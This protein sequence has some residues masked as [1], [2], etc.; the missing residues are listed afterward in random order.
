MSKNKTFQ[1]R[2]LISAMQKG[3]FVRFLSLS[4][5]FVLLFSVGAYSQQVIGSYPAMDGG[6]ENQTGT[7]PTASSISSAQTTWTTQVAAMGVIS[8]TGGRSGPKYV[9]YSQSGTPHKRLQ[10]PTTNVPTGAYRVQFWYQGDLDGTITASNI[11]GAVSGDGTATPAYA[12]YVSANTGST[13]TLYE[14][15]VTTTT[16][17]TNIGIGAVSV[18][19]TAQFKI[20]DYV[21]YSGSTADGTAPNAPTAPTQLSAAATQQTISWTAPSGGVDGGGYM[22]V[23][24]DVDPTTTPNTKGVYA[25]GNFVAGTEK[26]VYLGTANSFTD[27]GLTASTSYS[28]RIYAVDKAFNYSSAASI[29]ASTVAPSFASEP[30]TQASGVTFASI[31]IT[32]L[33]INWTG[34][35]GSNSLVVVKAGSAVDTDPTDGNTYTGNAAF[36]SGT[37]IGTGNYAVYNGSGNSVTLT[38][39][40]KLTTYY[41]KVY[42]FNGSAGTEN[43]LITTP[44]SGSQLTLPGEIYSNGTGGGNWST[45]GSWAGGVVPTQ[46][47]NVTIAASDVMTFT[48]SGKCYNLTIPTGTKVW[49]PAANTL[50]IYGTSLVCNGTGTLGDASIANSLLTVQFGGN[51]SIS[52]SSSSI[53][54]YKITPV[55]STSN[56]SVTFDAN[57][58]ITYGTVGLAF[59]NA[60]NDNITYTVS[61]G[62]TVTVAGALSATSSQTGVGA[63]NQT[64]KVYG[65]L[66]IGGSLNTTVASGKTFSLTVYSGGLIEVAKTTSGKGFNLSPA[67]SVQ[68]ATFTVNSGG[69]IK[70]YGLVD[71]SSTSYTGA[72]TG[73]GTFSTAISGLVGAP[74]YPEV[75]LGNASGLDATTG[76]IRTSAVNFDAGTGFLFVGTSPQVTGSNMPSTIA[77]LTVPAAGLTLSKSLTVN[78]NLNSSGVLT[79]G[80]NTFSLKGT[81][82]GSSIDGAN[83]TIV[84]IGDGAQGIYTLT[85]VN[86]LTVN[87]VIGQTTL[88]FPVTVNG[89]LTLAAGN[90]NNSTNNI[91]LANGATIVRTAGT[92]STAPVFGTS[93]NVTYNGASAQNT[94]NELPTSSSVLNNLIINNPAGITLAANATAANLTVNPS[95]VLNVGIGKQLTV[96]TALTNDGAINL[97]SDATG[98]ATI[99]TPASISGSG[100]STVQQYLTTGRNWYVSSPVSGATAAVFNPAGLSNILYSYDETHGSSAPWPAIT[101][102]ATGLTVMKG[103]VANMASSGVVTFS[104]TLNTGAQEIGLTQTSGQV[105]NGFNLVGNP[106]PSYLDWSSITKTNMLTTMWYRTKTSGDVYTFDTYNASGNIATSNGA[107]AVTNLIPPMQA[108]WVHVQTGFASSTLSV[109]NNQRAHADNS[110]NTF[111]AKASLETQP[112][113]RLQVSNGTN[114]DQALVY[115]NATA[116]NGFDSYDSPKLSNESASMPEIYTLAGS[117]QLVINGVN[118]ATELALGFTTGE[119]NNFSIKASQ[120]ANFASGTQIILRDNLLNYEQDLTLADYNFYS[121]VTANNETRFT[122]LFKAPSVATGINPNSNA[123]VWISLANNQIVVNGASAGTSVAVYNAVGQKI[124]SDMTQLKKSL[125]TGVY[126]VTVTNAGKS[127]TQKVIIK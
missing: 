83:G 103:Y 22:V 52:G 43:F 19:N 59:E 76:P 102:N 34:G 36:G 3:R 68:A 123:N 32:G 74:A 119:A 104:G 67:H 71:C 60:T 5:L 100:T 90:I 7:L 56:V 46:Y 1:N 54:P 25:V 126:M 33:T 111:K 115:F 47:D 85:N 109:T 80:A 51:L 98:T 81:N 40:S 64:L 116:S 66:S 38:G 57:T 117:E 12:S 99:L 41:V 4:V 65:T 21:I 9:T 62:K 14:A 45:A 10:S 31:G 61:A 86:N 124:M 29:T 63:G 114:S 89:T 77:N 113:L 106:Y 107:K 8:N 127:V 55:S 35:N 58:T 97:L 79:V 82:S 95:A 84:Y 28:Y 24:S 101:N 69:E 120:F 122:V 105:K 88:N 72:V 37:Q 27:L 23:R 48:A 16:N 49:A 26:V 2:T 42:T 108:F 93:V 96:S 110:S 18:I 94:S 15:T 112:V 30:T 50:A 73:A 92:L 78:G 125:A 118:D 20:D 11:R 17:T 44:P 53:Y 91:T 6:F 87:N 121:D 39:L 75:K 70:V 13:W